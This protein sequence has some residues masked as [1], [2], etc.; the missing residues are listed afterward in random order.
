MKLSSE[1]PRVLVHLWLMGPILR[2]HGSM[3][4]ESGGG[5]GMAGAGGARGGGDD[6]HLLQ[7]AAI[8]MR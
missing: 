7:S 3:R 1:A 5:L 8:I 2:R 4:R 6:G